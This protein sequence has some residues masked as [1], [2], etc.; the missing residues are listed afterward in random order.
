MNTCSNSFIFHRIRAI[1]WRIQTCQKQ[2]NV[3]LE[4]FYAQRTTESLI[5]MKRLIFSQRNHFALTSLLNWVSLVTT[6]VG[7]PK[8]TTTNQLQI[9]YQIK[10]H[11][12]R[13][14]NEIQ[15]RLHHWKNSKTTLKIC[16]KLSCGLTSKD[17]TKHTFGANKEI[18]SSNPKL[19]NPLVLVFEM[20]Y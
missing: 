10:K 2:L 17:S 20:L 8:P 1:F 6:L 5:R 13:S 12:N 9:R 16:P 18:F 14:N 11:W 15:N 7:I 3:P 4:N 19:K